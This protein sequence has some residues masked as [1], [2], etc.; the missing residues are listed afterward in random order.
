MQAKFAAM[1][2]ELEGMLKEAQVRKT[3]ADA[4]LA[5]ARAGSEQIKAAT[6][7][8]EASN[9][10]EPSEASGPRQRPDSQG[11]RRVQ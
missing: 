3:H 8:V 5:L 10:P 1:M 9:P 7:V 11:Q 4:D 6:S 2:Q